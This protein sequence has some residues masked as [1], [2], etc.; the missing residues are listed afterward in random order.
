ML[1]VIA[2]CKDD[3]EN[4]QK[5]LNSLLNID[6]HFMPRLIKRIIV[7]DG[8]STDDTIE[9]QKVFSEKFRQAGVEFNFISE[10]DNGIF[11]AM[12]AALDLCCKEDLIWF[13][14]AGDIVSE[15]LDIENVLSSL[16]KFELSESLICFFVSNNVFQNTNYLMPPNKIQ[17]KDSFRNWMKF[18][19]PVHQAVIV[20]GSSKF[21]HF[22]E[23]FKV[24]ADS[25]QIY[26]NFLVSKEVEFY[27][28]TICKFFLG[29][30]SGNYSSLNILKS[31]LREQKLIS[32]LRREPWLS[33]KLRSCSFFI[34]Y[35][36]Q[37]LFYRH[38]DKIQAHAR[39]LFNRL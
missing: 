4:L 34:K 9:I 3:S 26:M 28:F 11:S 18:N 33:V 24:S 35:L 23:D 38:Y 15:V 7:K 5:T 39:K 1:T 6:P 10:V 27:P 19:T 22:N 2:V 25:I 29:G 21:L 14:N 17:D 12:N 20:K 13:L 36:I 30:N 16:K 32:L 31:R 37:K 8:C